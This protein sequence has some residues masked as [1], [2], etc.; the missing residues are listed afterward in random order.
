MLLVCSVNLAAAAAVGK[1]GAVAPAPTGDQVKGGGTA[2]G[3][4]KGGSVTPAPTPAPA[5]ATGKGAGSPVVV[6]PGTTGP[7][8]STG[9]D[10]PATKGSSGQHTSTGQTGGS[11]GSGGSGST[12]VKG[13]AGVVTPAA[14]PTPS[15]PTTPPTVS[16]TPPTGH[17]T[18]THRHTSHDRPLTHGGQTGSTQTPS[19]LP[20]AVVLGFSGA[21]PAAGAAHHLRTPAVSGSGRGGASG[22]AAAPALVAREFASVVRVVPLWAWIL[23][24]VMLILLLASAGATARLARRLRRSDALVG[25]M[26]TAALTDPLTGLLNRRGFGDRLERELARARRFGHPLAVAFLDVRG[27]KA[28]NDDHGHSAGDAV[29]RA[30][31]QLVRSSTR[32]EDI[33]GRIGGDEC[34]V[35]LIEQDRAGAVAFA[36]RIAAAVPGARD[37]LGTGTDW[38]LTVGVAIFPEDGETGEELLAAADRRLYLRRG[39]ALSATRSSK[40]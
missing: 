28:V 16:I 38:D 23:V 37:E 9:G 40:D 11:A 33:V 6:P 5:P 17:K 29:L 19:P 31:A 35:G 21:T 22:I 15:T 25:S 39:I 14:D 13:R 10:V 36:R 32:E 12:S 20:A 34:A 4:G 2:G 7:G 18:P 1:G 24:A 27:L 3:G 30:A 26:R 8:G